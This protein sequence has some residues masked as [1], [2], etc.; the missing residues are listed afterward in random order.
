MQLVE[1]TLDDDDYDKDHYPPRRLHRKSVSDSNL[2]PY[3]PRTFPKTKKNIDESDSSDSHASLDNA[4]LA[5]GSQSEAIN[6]KSLENEFK[7]LMYLDDRNDFDDDNDIEDYQRSTNAPPGLGSDQVKSINPVEKQLDSIFRQ[8]ISMNALGYEIKDD[9][10]KSASI[11]P[12][13]KQEKASNIFS[14][15]VGRWSI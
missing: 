13:A 9:L 5:R 6:L 7:I 3:F 14:T 8:E 4:D 11:K 10:P 1:D 12:A 2:E 15:D